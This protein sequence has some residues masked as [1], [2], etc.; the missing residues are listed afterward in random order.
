M[1]AIVGFGGEVA[2]LKPPRS[3]LKI[4][5]WCPP[6]TSEVVSGLKAQVEAKLRMYCFVLR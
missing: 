1:G 4:P 3:R 5:R 2:R 6:C